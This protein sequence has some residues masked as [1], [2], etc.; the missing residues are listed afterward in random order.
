MFA[1]DV[2][3]L[4]KQR[5]FARAWDI[6]AIMTYSLLLSFFNKNFYIKKISYDKDL[7]TFHPKKKYPL[8][9]I[10]RY[11]MDLPLMKILFARGFHFLR[12]ILKSK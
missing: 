6:I 2:E 7:S 9:R 4:Q 12:I 10:I 3:C 5:M 1:K 8:L 11:I